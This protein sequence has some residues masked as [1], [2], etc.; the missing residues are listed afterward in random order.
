MAINMVDST[1]IKRFKSLK[2]QRKIVCLTSYSAPMTYAL[3]PYCDLLLVGDSVA[4]VVYGMDNTR[5]ADLDMMIRHGQAVMRRRQKSVVIIDL[6]SGSYEN[7]PQQALASARKVIDET[8]ADGVKIEGG[9]GIAEHVALLVSSGIAVLAHIGLLPQH[10]T[11][12][13][14]YRITGR[15]AEDAARLANDSRVLCK[16]GV[17]GI[18]MEGIIEPV[19]A[20]IA[21]ECS[22]PT[23]GI[24]ASPACD[25]Q[26][27]VTEDI[28]GLYDAFTPKFAK[29]FANLQDDIGVAAA[30]F[31]KAV[32]SETFPHT[33]HLFW[34]KNK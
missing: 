14:G 28:L 25:G 31:Q 17:F 26:I 6:P 32:V 11:S 22:V 12:P 27:L 1:R 4:M 19:A 29:K 21:A 5:G 33:Q 7:S 30:A 9:T 20:S 13:S 15:T 16:A 10:V 2:G 23:I 18:V 3:D 8:G 34:P 24:G